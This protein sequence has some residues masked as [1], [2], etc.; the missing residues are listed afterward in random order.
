MTGR[1]R[2]Q[3]TQKNVRLES[4]QIK[5]QIPQAKITKGKANPG[6]A[7]IMATGVAMSAAGSSDTTA[8]PAVVP[9]GM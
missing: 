8:S 5:A 2:P 3:T 7:K 4:P 9:I 1:A 6:F